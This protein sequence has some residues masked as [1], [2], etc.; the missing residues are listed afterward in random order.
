LLHQG[1]KEVCVVEMTRKVG[2]D[3]GNSTRWTVM[4][5]LK[6]LG[7]KIIVGAKAIEVT[8]AGLRI[9]KESREALLLADSIVMATGSR[10][11]NALASLKDLA[12]EVYVIGDAKKPRNALKAIR[13]GFLTGLKI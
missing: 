1:N 10:S 8:E 11:E 13:D 5:G 12:P 2:Q 4:A 3:I 7:V 6:R 9:Q